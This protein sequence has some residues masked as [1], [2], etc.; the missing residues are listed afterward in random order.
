MQGKKVV[1]RPNDCIFSVGLQTF[2]SYSKLEGLLM[3]MYATVFERLVLKLADAV[4]APSRDTA[5]TL[6]RVYG[7]GE[8]T[9]VI[10]PGSE[11]EPGETHNSIR[12]EYGF[13]EEQALIILL[14]TGDNFR[15]RAAIQF[16]QETLAPFLE[17]EAPDARIMIVGRK[18]EEFRDKIKTRNL[19]IVGEVPATGPYLESAD[20]AIAPM[21]IVGGVSAKVIE[22]L[23]SGLPT[24]A[25]E[26][27]IRTI[28][29]RQGVIV[30]DLH[31]FCQDVSTAIRDVQALRSLRNAI[32][33]EALKNYSWD[34]IGSLTTRIIDSLWSNP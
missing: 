5:S 13:T 16:T 28:D 7:V 12:C 3:L 15:N 22:Y 9:Y 31:N 33:Q 17:R 26:S 29:Q 1:L 24:V 32:R 6:E 34:N 21:T 18:T 8:K 20:L 11:R 2:S 23:C 4:L 27:S 30:S 25:T 10:P 14:A 19:V